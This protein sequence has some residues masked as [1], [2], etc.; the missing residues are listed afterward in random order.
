MILIAESPRR[1]SQFEAY[2]QAERDMDINEIRRLHEVIEQRRK[3]IR[4]ADSKNLSDAR[5][6]GEKLFAKQKQKKR[7]GEWTK[8]VEANLNFTTRHA[9]N[10]I[11]IYREWDRLQQSETPVSGLRAAL[12]YLRKT[13]APGKK[14]S[15]E[16]TAS[17]SRASRPKQ[18]RRK[19]GSDPPAFSLKFEGSHREHIES[20]MTQAREYTRDL[21]D[22]ESR[23][24]AGL[25]ALVELRSRHASH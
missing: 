6:L 22:D 2:V 15:S 21:P 18:K 7:D 1:I 24:I 25:L 10:Y 19:E 11:R 5:C 13:K 8:W 4:Q 3:E 12:A 23:V 16:A 17:G 9:G 20:A 14:G